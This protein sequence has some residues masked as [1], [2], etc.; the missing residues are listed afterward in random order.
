M[1]PWTQFLQLYF[2]RMDFSELQSLLSRELFKVPF[3][4]TVCWCFVVSYLPGLLRPWGRVWPQVF[5]TEK[6]FFSHLHNLQYN[7]HFM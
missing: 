5:T 7:I 1:L 2:P 4:F 3:S 6:G